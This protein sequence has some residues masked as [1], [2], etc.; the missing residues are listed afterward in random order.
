MAFG[1]AKIRS[2][3]SVGPEIVSI[4]IH[5]AAYLLEVTSVPDIHISETGLRNRD[6]GP[7]SKECACT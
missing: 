4:I 7:G 3:E 6:G 5:L 1:L 2:Q